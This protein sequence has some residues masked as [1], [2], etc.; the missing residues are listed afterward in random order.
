MISR[1]A[2]ERI[3]EFDTSYPIGCDFGFLALAARHYR[4]HM[5]S[6]PACIKHEYAGKGK[7]LTE[8]H[9]ATGATA[10]Q[11]AKD[12]LR[13]HET[14]FWN[15]RQSDPELS[16]L[17]A[18]AQVHLARLILDRGRVDEAIPYLASAVEACPGP[19]AR[20]LLM[21]ARSLPASLAR[22]F[23]RGIF[24]AEATYA[25]IARRARGLLRG[26]RST[27]QDGARLPS[28]SPQLT[29]EKN[30]SDTR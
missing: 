15:D 19:E 24:R 4:A 6:A 20:L 26:A 23:S 18:W 10:P 29:V 17:R 9:L 28:K 1:T 16:A 2:F 21:A 3:G 8:E 30:L 12:L 27:T 11:F 14:L 22:G 7:L 13:W 5:V 25:R